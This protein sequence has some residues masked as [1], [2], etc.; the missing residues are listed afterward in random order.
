VD[1][2]PHAVTCARKNAEFN[3]VK[4]K[5]EVRLG[6]LFE[7]VGVAEKFDVILFNAPYL[8]VERD[9]GANWIEKAWVGGEK[10][11]AVIDRFIEQTSD[12]LEVGG[13]ILLVQSS[14]SDVEETL[15]R[16]H[17]CALHAAVIGEE[18]LDFERIVLVEAEAEPHE[19]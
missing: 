12:H 4:T 2:N 6:D 10:G 9:E 3:G 14:L 17:Q 8:P 11:R 7:A 19:P 1:I 18:K 16:L 13:R 15:R 5:I